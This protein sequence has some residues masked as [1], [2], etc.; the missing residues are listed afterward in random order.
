[1]RCAIVN[2][3]CILSG[4]WREPWV[5]GDRI[6]SV[7]G[8]LEAVGTVS[9]ADV[10]EADVVIDADGAT[11][12][13][14]F[15]DSQVHNT[16]G[17]YTPPT[18]VGAPFEVPA[19]FAERSAITHVA[20]IKTPLMLVEGEADARTPAP[21]GGEPL[22]RALR[23]RKAPT[24]MVRFPGETHDLS[25]SGQPWHRVERLRHIVGWFDKFVIGKP[26]IEYDVP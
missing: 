16:F 18:D 10:A 3:G 4:S 19:E 24:V 9:D 13:P 5:E 8:Q 26:S 6:L 23:Y 21:A 12:A 14:G 1:M 7:D 15:I 2:L 25:R 17:D 22:F 20:R 11:A